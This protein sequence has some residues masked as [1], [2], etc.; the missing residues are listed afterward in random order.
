MCPMVSDHFTNG[1][2]RL[3]LNDVLFLLLDVSGSLFIFSSG[4]RGGQSFL[5]SH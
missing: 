1:S 3:G 2:A 4:L 5:L